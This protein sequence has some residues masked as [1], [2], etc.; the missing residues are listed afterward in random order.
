MACPACLSFWLPRR[1]YRPEEY[2]DASASDPAVGRF[3]VSDGATDSSFSG[4]WAQLLVNDFVQNAGHDPAQSDA[5]F[6]ALQ[7]QW[8]ASSAIQEVL[9]KIARD[10][11]SSWSIEAK[12]MEGA[13]ATFLGL[14]LT[15]ASGG[16]PQWEATAVGDTCL[17]HT[18]GSALLSA[19]PVDQSSKFNNS[20]RLLGSRMSLERV[21][22]TPVL[23]IEGSG[24]AGDRLWMMT[25]ALAQWYL[26]EH[27]DGRDPW[28]EIDSL[29][30]RPEP[31]QD[32]A[33]W[34]EE[35]RC[36]RQLHNDD[37][38]LLLITL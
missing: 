2:E 4:L 24:L 21:R 30:T 3:A 15:S 25:D 11:L 7:E 17:F 10:P 23:H 1:G 20:P 38:T 33:A 6:P 35:L 8:Y 16:I 36:S 5:Y 27:E 9:K 19:F 13:Y 14:S 22:K 12:L 29:L 26:R 32:F 28:G 37:V 18:R 34:I 31:Q